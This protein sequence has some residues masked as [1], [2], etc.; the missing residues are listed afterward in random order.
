MAIALSH[1]IGC[2]LSIRGMG[3]ADCARERGAHEPFVIVGEGRRKRGFAAVIRS[4]T[5]SFAFDEAAWFQKANGRN[6]EK[7]TSFRQ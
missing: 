7:N 3:F 4:L 1:G 2:H 6:E 5:R